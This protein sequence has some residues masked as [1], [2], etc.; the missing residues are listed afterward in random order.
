M[1]IAGEI[2]LISRQ[3]LEKVK[4]SGPENLMALCPFHVKSDGSPESH[5][6]FAISTIT[7]LWFCHSC[8]AKGNLY[9]FL[10]DLGL[11][12]SEISFRYQPLLD[13]AKK[14]LPPPPDPTRP[15]E[16]FSSNPLP[17]GL[18]GIF[19]YCP[20]KLIE[21]GFKEET[22]RHFDIG[23]DVQHMRVTYPIR[24]LSGSLVAISGR[25]VTDSWPKYKIYDTEYRLW[26]LPERKNWDKRTALWNAHSVYPEL[27]FNHAPA[28]IVVV[29]GFKACMWVWQAGIKNV[30][31]LLGTYLSWEH[32]W[33]LERLGAT[34][35]LFLDN[36]QPG[37]KGTLKCGQRLKTSLPVK[38]IQYPEHLIG[39]ETAQP[40]SCTA[41]EI[42]EQVRTAVSYS[43][44]IW[45]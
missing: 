42:Q 37:R 40:D 1:D 10:R 33:I 32:Q 14:N 17:E 27:Y 20:T 11:S 35:C 4:P 21:D 23:F 29:E 38:V 8:Q 5:P 43:E 6:S 22:L 28:E 15:G 19:D 34:V 36:N 44:W 39:E 18:L 30:V 7:G 9:T 13:A 31:A 2:Q 45:N 41:E 16:I 12:S 25:A 24:D 26:D 3:Y